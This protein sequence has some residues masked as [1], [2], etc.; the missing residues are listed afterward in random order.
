LYRPY[1]VQMFGGPEAPRA[2]DYALRRAFRIFPAYWVALTVLGLWPGLGGVFT[3]KWWVY[4]GLLQ[5]YSL[6]WLVRGI[7]A[8]WSLSVEA[9]F[10]VLLPLVGVALSRAGRRLDPPGRMRLQLLAFAALGLGGLAFRA[11]V[12]QAAFWNLFNTLP[13]YFFSFS[14]GMALAVSSAWLEGRESQCWATR[15][16]TAHSGCCWATA[17]VL[18][19]ATSLSPAFPRAASGIPMT[20]VAFTAESAAYTSIALLVM[21]PAVFGEHAGGLPR[22]V[23]RSRSLSWIG[24]IS[25]GVFL[26][27]TPLLRA[28]RVRFLRH[29]PPGQAFLALTLLI[30]P[31]ALALGWLSWRWIEKPA[32]RVA[33]SLGGRGALAAAG[34][35]ELGQRPPTP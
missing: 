9:A 10:Y 27:H 35:E 23:L 4:Y 7:G 20:T 19:L 28:A 33:R 8:A 24:K 34:T 3:N 13:A 31:L 25:Y 17:V 11:G 15:F 6:S 2:H 22:R 30:L 32:M 18:F 29:L 12:Y 26:W 14:V 21:L 5:S 16:V 1:A